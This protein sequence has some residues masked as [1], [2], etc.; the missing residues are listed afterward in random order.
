MTGIVDAI[1]GRKIS[2]LE[3]SDIACA[4][5]A[6]VNTLTRLAVFQFLKPLNVHQQDPT[7]VLYRLH[8][9]ECQVHF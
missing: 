3:E 4:Y 2:L 9:T 6:H 5:F 7:V 8:K 1:I